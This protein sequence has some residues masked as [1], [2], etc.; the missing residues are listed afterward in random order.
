MSIEPTPWRLEVRRSLSSDQLAAVARLVQAETKWLGEEPLSDAARLALRTAQSGPLAE[1]APP[2]WHGL[3]WIGTALAAYVQVRT[4]GFDHVAEMAAS[5]QVE[6]AAEAASVL[7]DIRERVGVPMTLWVRGDADPAAAVARKLALRPIRTLL[8][9]RV[10]L[11]PV[12]AAPA[13]KS[14]LRCPPGFSLR[15]FGAGVDD[16]AWLAVNGAAF[17]DLPDQGGWTRADLAARMAEP[18]FRQDGFFLVVTPTGDI[19]AF[20]WTKIQLGVAC[21]C[22]ADCGE[23]YVLGVSPPYQ[24]HGL[25]RYLT[26]VGL[27]YFRRLGITTAMLYVDE[28]NAAAIKTYARCGFKVFQ[29]AREFAMP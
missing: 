6:G 2:T 22:A 27:D 25:G 24:G 23:I 21:G 1:K 19:A 12:S 4:E 7:R 17:A 18:W 5:A 9:M 10:Q 15:T 8:Q 26:S 14:P 11:E 28:S 20:H 3:V 29:T 13:Q 16:D